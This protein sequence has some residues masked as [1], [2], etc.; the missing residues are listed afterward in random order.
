MSSEDQ[1]NRNLK[2]KQP[3][4]LLLLSLSMKGR[5]LLSENDELPLPVDRISNRILG[6]GRSESDLLDCTSGVR[7]ER[8]GM[9]RDRRSSLFSTRR[10]K[11]TRVSEGRTEGDRN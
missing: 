8:V 5:M 10:N 4:R 11:M 7:D 2:Q 9:V 6:L 3:H 1:A